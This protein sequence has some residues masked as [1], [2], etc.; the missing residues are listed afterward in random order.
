MPPPDALK[1]A[2]LM[3]ALYTLG[4]RMY[5]K[6]GTQIPSLAIFANVAFFSGGFSLAKTVGWLSFYV[7]LGPAFY[8]MVNGPVGNKESTIFGFRTR[9]TAALSGI[10]IPGEI[11]VRVLIGVVTC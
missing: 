5:L 10:Q 1:R 2:P 3:H 6:I 9:E 4:P 11:V 7:A 8:F